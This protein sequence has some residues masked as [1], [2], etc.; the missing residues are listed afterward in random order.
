MVSSS[1]S[2]NIYRWHK[3]RISL[4]KFLDSIESKAAI[5]SWK[6]LIG[7]ESS[8]KKNNFVIKLSAQIHDVV[9]LSLP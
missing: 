3:I 1:S 6:K 4:G 2:Q 5:L 8:L 9:D 7:F